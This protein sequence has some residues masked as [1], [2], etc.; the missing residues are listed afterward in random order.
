LHLDTH[1]TRYPTSTLLLAALGF[2]QLALRQN[3]GVYIHKHGTGSGHGIN[4]LFGRRVKA[5]T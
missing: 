1:F 3:I 2:W 4:L 5:R